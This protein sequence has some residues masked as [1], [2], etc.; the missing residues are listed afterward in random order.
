M[1]VISEDFCQKYNYNS[2]TWEVIDCEDYISDSNHIK[3]AGV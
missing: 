3:V 1:N 2:D